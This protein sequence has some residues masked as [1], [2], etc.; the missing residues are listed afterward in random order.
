[1][2]LEP[3]GCANSAVQFVETKSLWL[4]GTA[5]RIARQKSLEGYAEDLAH[6]VIGKLQTMPDE[7]W[8]K[9]RN[10]NAY[11]ATMMA[12][13]ANDIYRQ[14]QKVKPLD[15]LDD[16]SLAGL[17]AARST[18]PQAREA[19]I[20]VQQWRRMLEADEQD[21]FNLAFEE[22][23]SRIE[24]AQ[25]LGISNDAARRRVSRLLEK[26]RRIAS[27]PEFH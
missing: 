26:L 22:G 24:I 14:H 23:F 27:G 25:K 7:Q 17:P 1:M 6:D 21:L 5:R 12:H 9:V 8:A 13:L 10:Q 11:V 19:A 3:D 16:A 2:L 20:M 15:D 4:Y 18:S